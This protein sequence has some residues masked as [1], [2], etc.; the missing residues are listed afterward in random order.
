M[1][2]T[3]SKR[4][5][6]ILLPIALLLLLAGFGAT[7]LVLSQY[8]F[9]DAYLSNSLFAS[10]GDETAGDTAFNNVDLRQTLKDSGMAAF[11]AT[12]NAAHWYLGWLQLAI[13][14]VVGLAGLRRPLV[15]R[16]FMLMALLQTLL[17]LPLMFL[18]IRLPII[19]MRAPGFADR[20]HKG[21]M[22]PGSQEQWK[23]QFAIDHLWIFIPFLVVLA[24]WFTVLGLRA[25]RNIYWRSYD[26]SPD[27]GD[28]LLENV[29]THGRTPDLR[30]GS[31]ISVA[32]HLLVLLGLPW[33]LGIGG[34]SDRYDLPKGSGDPS[35]AM[36]VQVQ[37]KEKKKERLVVN[38]NSPFIFKQPRIED[39]EVFD[40]LDQ[41]TQHQYTATTGQA[42]GEGGGN[43][44]GWP[45]GVEKAKVRFIRLKLSGG[46]DWDQDMGEG[47]DYNFLIKFGELTKFHI[48]P[49]TEAIAV[50]QITNFPSGKAPPF[51]YL[52]GGLRGGI[53]ISAREKEIL[54]EYLVE[55]GG[56]IFAD[57]GG[58]A[59]NRDFRQMMK[60]V[61]PE[62][63]MVTISH[64]D[65]IF[66]YPNQ[67]P[68]GAPELWPH[69]SPAGAQGIKHNGRW[70]VFYHPGDINDAWKTGHSGV[71]PIV[72]N[73]AYNMG[74]NVVY[75]S[76]VQYYKQ[77]YS[78]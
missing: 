56:M 50:S 22:S 16:L 8:P 40:E 18:Y 30:R 34:C 64:D 59:F 36:Q 55:E 5:Q 7:N 49:N 69:S 38:M 53:R 35:V 43:T 33:L 25:T 58:P 44:G 10:A 29:R 28:R 54:R 45:Q 62:Y 73:Q 9:F 21:Y 3:L 15:H 46:I 66:Q 47:A 76:Y 51:L 17:L 78:N 6:K 37:K 63:D 26:R 24:L 13:F 27:W 60:Q 61:L 75:Y 23:Y 14:V 77:H 39:S 4:L 68:E 19:L 70:V 52:T 1:K 2:F 71:K 41:E 57:A 48:A 67:F 20:R 31:Y 12:T 65:P 32:L 72:A 74:I 42:I 11:S